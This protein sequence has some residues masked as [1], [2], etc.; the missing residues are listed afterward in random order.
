VVLFGE[1]VKAATLA[2]AQ[3]A[4]RECKLLLVVGTA[5]DVAPAVD[6][7]SLANS[8]GAK[9][10]EVKRNPSRLTHTAQI[11]SWLPGDAVDVLP[12]LVEAIEARDS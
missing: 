2:T 6:L 10:V 9:V 1:R 3:A 8:G 5:L 4:A 11:D 12:L 7:V